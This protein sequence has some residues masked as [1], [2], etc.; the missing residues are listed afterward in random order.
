MA[1]SATLTMLKSR[2]TMNEVVRIRAKAP[3]CRRAQTGSER[4]AAGLGAILAQA[5]TPVAGVALRPDGRLDDVHDATAVDSGSPSIW[6]S[7]PLIW[8]KD[9]PPLWCRP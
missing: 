8:G 1:A 2:T 3:A 4:G 5:K 6:V 7:R 9:R